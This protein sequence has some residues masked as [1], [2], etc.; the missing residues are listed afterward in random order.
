LR[1]FYD[2]FRHGIRHEDIIDP[3]S[4]FECSFEFFPYSDDDGKSVIYEKI[5]SYN[6][7][8]P[9]NGTTNFGFYIQKAALPHID[10]ETTQSNTLVG[11]FPIPGS[12]IKPTSNKFSMEIV[13]V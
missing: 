1:D 7:D 5:N 10:M 13:N 6:Y 9:P 3:Y 8:A 2:K 11:T 12:I 4:T